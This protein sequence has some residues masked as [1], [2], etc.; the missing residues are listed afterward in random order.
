[1]EKKEYATPVLTVHGEVETITQATLGAHGGDSFGKSIQ[2]IP[3]G[4][5]S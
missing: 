4:P 3:I 5:P 2:G 1:M